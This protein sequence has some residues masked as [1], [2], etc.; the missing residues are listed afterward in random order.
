MASNSRQCQTGPAV[1]TAAANAVYFLL[2]LLDFWKAGA[3]LLGLGVSSLQKLWHS[4]LPAAAV[5]QF[6]TAKQ[7]DMAYQLCNGN[8]LM[9]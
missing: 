1:C 9:L 3:R 2:Q 5:Y 8:S 4:I 7:R 6:T